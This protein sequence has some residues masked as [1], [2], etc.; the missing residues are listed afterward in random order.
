MWV[1]GQCHAPASS[2]QGKRPGSKCKDKESLYRLS[3]LWTGHFYHPESIHGTHFCQRLSWLQGHCKAGSI[4]SMK[5]FNDTNGKWTPDLPAFIA[6]PQSNVPLHAPKI[7]CDYA[8]YLRSPWV[9]TVLGSWSAEMMRL[10]E[11]SLAKI[12]CWLP[13]NHQHKGSVGIQK[14]LIGCHNY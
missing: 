4:M 13:Y 6:V 9:E 11:V 3:A 1:S 12:M 14:F 10:Y 2:P 7:K 8:L 5:N